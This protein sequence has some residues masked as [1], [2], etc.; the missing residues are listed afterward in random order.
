MATSES[1]DVAKVGA[2]NAASTATVA[3]SVAATDTPAITIDGSELAEPSLTPVP[4]PPVPPTVGQAL[5]SARQAAN[6]SVA[7]VAQILKFSPRQI[8]ALEA[9][10]HAALPGTTI[11]RGFVRSY[12]KLLKL[13]S[14]VLLQSLNHSTP[15]APADV[16]PPDNMG[17][18]SQP[19]SDR[20][21]S[22]LL[23]IA[24]VLALAAVLLALWHFLGPT[25][26]KT[27]TT[28]LSQTA[29][30]T[31]E[32]VPVAPINSANPADP[33]ATSVAAQAVAGTGAP[34]GGPGAPANGAA[35]VAG[36][37]LVFTFQDR[38]WVEVTDATK[39]KLHSAE[40]PAGTKLTL[41][42]KPPYEVVVG[43]AAKASLVY[44]D[45]VIDLAP[46]TRAEVARL[47][48]E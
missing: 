16:R 24:I 40:N 38:C 25:A 27:S 2:E 5:R 32:Q 39:Q 44:G 7:E 42:G 17:V 19:G 4:P 18:A 14:G 8:E 13:D 3:E 33:G 15:N 29:P 37:A 41:S 36:P 6:L 31:T 10:D 43:N 26:G 35:P 30:A 22:P 23:S 46:Y 9:D 11:V 34:P 45:R 21:I 28:P 20:Q 1:E 47:T 48:V 12:A